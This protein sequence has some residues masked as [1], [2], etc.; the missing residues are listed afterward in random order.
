MAAKTRVLQALAATPQLLPQGL[1]G[2]QV[3]PGSHVLPHCGPQN[4]LSASEA[5][6]TCSRGPAHCWNQRALP[7]ALSPLDGGQGAPSRLAG[8]TCQHRMTCS[9]WHGREV[10]WPQQLS[11]YPH[12]VQESLGLLPRGPARTR[13]ARP[14]PTGTAERGGRLRPRGVTMDTAPSHLL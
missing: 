13:G 14:P 8:L 9:D 4:V 3:C 6:L 2:Q 7:T 12:L 5:W 10:Y 1:S 11:Q